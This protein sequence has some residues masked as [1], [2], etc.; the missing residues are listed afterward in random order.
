MEVNAQKRPLDGRSVEGEPMNR[1]SWMSVVAVSAAA[2]CACSSA[3]TAK[4][5]AK[6]E[7]SAAE[8]RAKSEDARRAREEKVAENY[9]GKVPEWAI[10]PPRSDADGFYA[11]GIS[12]S[13]RLD[14]ALKKSMLT[15]EY[16]L[17]KSYKAVIS[18]NERQYQRDAGRGAV[19]EQYT[20]LIDQ[21]VDRVPLAGYDVVKR[22]VRTIDG[23]Y[24][25]FVL[26]HLSY[27]QLNK[28]LESTKK[29]DADASIDEQFSVLEQRLDKYRADRVAESQRRIV[30]RAADQSAGQKEKAN[31]T[32]TAQQA[33]IDVG[34]RDLTGPMNAN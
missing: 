28:A 9:M 33:E 29:A 12:E 14:T 27:E 18:G 20:L 1:T 6:E 3:P 11:V 25:S 23:T 16:D 26:L 30:A 32:G 15:A 5:I 4:D 7:A 10:V 22:E 31:G 2:L 19:A 13:S 21:I 34:H 8:V 24:H 17:A